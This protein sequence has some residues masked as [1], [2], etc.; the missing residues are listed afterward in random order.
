MVKHSWRL[1]TI[2]NMGGPRAGTEFSATCRTHYWDVLA[3]ISLWK[4]SFQYYQTRVDW[5]RRYPLLIPMLQLQRPDLAE[6]YRLAV[7]N[8]LFMTEELL[9]LIEEACENSGLGFPI[10]PRQTWPGPSIPHFLLY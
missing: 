10:A 9:A 7:R 8:P 6:L 5:L 3:A 2:V 4:W 1:I